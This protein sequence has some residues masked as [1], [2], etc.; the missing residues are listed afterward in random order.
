MAL[1]KNYE[2]AHQNLSE[3]LTSS[4]LYEEREQAIAHLGKTAA[5]LASV[6]EEFGKA[7]DNRDIPLDLWKINSDAHKDS[8]EATG[9]LL[10]IN[11]R[12]TQAGL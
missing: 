11:R 1:G 5:Y 3:E 6:M 7:R 4:E 12:I 2:M 10:D 8:V 9:R